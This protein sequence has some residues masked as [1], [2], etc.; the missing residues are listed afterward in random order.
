MEHWYNGP[1]TPLTHSMAGQIIIITGGSRGIGWEAA[2]DL[3]KQGAKIIFG[4]RTIKNTEEKNWEEG[5]LHATCND[6]LQ[7][8][9][10]HLK[11]VMPTFRLILFGETNGP[12]IIKSISILGEDETKIRIGLFKEKYLNL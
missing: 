10:L 2:K 4:N 11:D 8:N 9:N 6:L 7:Q 1:K 12:D 3:L 5:I